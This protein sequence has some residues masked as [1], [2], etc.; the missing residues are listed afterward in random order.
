ML[1]GCKGINHKYVVVEWRKNP[2]IDRI[3]SADRSCIVE[4]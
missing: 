4:I 1:T 2:G 3:Y